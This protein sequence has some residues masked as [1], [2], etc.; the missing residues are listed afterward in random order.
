MRRGKVEVF[1]RWRQRIRK[2]ADA[3]QVAI[4]SFQL[5]NFVFCRAFAF[6]A[7]APEFWSTITHAI[8]P[9]ESSSEYRQC[10]ATPLWADSSR[11]ESAVQEREFAAV[12]M[13]PR[14]RRGE[15][16]L[17]DA[18]LTW[19]VVGPNCSGGRGHRLP[20]S[21]N[22]R[23]SIGSVIT[24]SVANS[25][26]VNALHSSARSACLLARDRRTASQ[27]MQFPDFP[28]NFDRSRRIFGKLW[29]MV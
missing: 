26:K 13:L 12:N 29:T 7:P 16:A 24:V 17:V 10:L 14:V 23:F 20:V 15:L 21:L 28:S 18:F 9:V 3:E 6:P 8:T 4:D 2:A 25:L 22:W 19:A 27:A 11:I 5:G 1:H